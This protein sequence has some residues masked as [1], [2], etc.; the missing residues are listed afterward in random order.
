MPNTVIYR[1]VLI[2]ELI[3]AERLNSYINVFPHQSDAEI[4]GAYLWNTAV[5]AAFA[6]VMQMAEV[7]LR[8]AID[9]A[10]SASASPS[11]PPNRFWWRGGRLAYKSYVANAPEPDVVVKI[12][13]NFQRAHSSVIMEKRKR[14]RVRGHI[15]PT[16]HEL[17]AKTDFSTWEFIFDHEFMAPGLF[18]PQHLSKVFRGPWG[19]QTPS[20][21]L[22][23]VVGLVRAVRQLRNRMSHHEPLW[24]AAGVSSEQ[25]AINYVKDKLKQMLDLIELVFPEN[26]KLLERAMLLGQ[27]ERIC[28]IPELERFK[29]KTKR[30]NVKSRAKFEKIAAS[31]HGQNRIAWVKVYR[32]KGMSFFI[33]PAL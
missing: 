18:W 31:C 2:D 8:N 32:N 7:S 14:Y 23:H 26:I 4:V 27:A 10:L 24:K 1:P 28:S 20:Q 25:A 21:L 11:G 22:V 12:R 5:C 3:T 9:T 30:H 29:L 15:H 19:H 13:Q 17:V 6:P 16:H 33:V